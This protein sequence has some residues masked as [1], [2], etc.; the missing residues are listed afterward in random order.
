MVDR[1]VVVLF[2]ALVLGYA[3]YTKIATPRAKSVN[4]EVFL[5][6]QVLNAGAACLYPFGL[7]ACG[8]YRFQLDIFNV[9][10]SEGSTQAVPTGDNIPT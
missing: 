5:L 6:H 7:T 8:R 9:C 2:I 10:I 3:S 4:E 1:A